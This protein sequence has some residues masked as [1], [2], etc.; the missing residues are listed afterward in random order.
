[1]DFANG[2]FDPEYS[3]HEATDRLHVLCD[4]LE[5]RQVPADQVEA[6]RALGDRFLRHMQEQ[7]VFWE[8]LRDYAGRQLL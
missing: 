7:C 6:L 4:E 5:R 3:P 1:M 2:P 8:R